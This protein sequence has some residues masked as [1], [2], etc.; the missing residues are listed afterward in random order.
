MVMARPVQSSSRQG[1]HHHSTTAVGNKGGVHLHGFWEPL[2]ADAGRTHHLAIEAGDAFVGQ[3]V[4]V[5]VQRGGLVAEVL[6][7]LLLLLLQLLQDGL[8]ILMVL[9]QI[10]MTLQQG[11]LMFQQSGRHRIHS[12]LL[13]SSLLAPRCTGV[14]QLHGLFQGTDVRLGVLEGVLGHVNL[15]TRF[16]QFRLQ[17]SPH[18]LVLIHALLHGFVAFLRGILRLSLHALDQLM[19]LF[20]ELLGG[21]LAMNG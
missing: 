17:A 5:D 18:L 1:H 11:H 21:L 10:F 19:C 3:A 8:L 7:Q 9:L 4:Q 16:A 6:L 15:G 2:A 20:P 13:G 12:M 14:G